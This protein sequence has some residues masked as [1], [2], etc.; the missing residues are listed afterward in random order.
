MCM[1]L[2]HVISKTKVPVFSILS[3]GIS[4]SKV[5]TSKLGNLLGQ[6]PRL[7]RGDVGWRHRGNAFGHHHH[8]LLFG[9]PRF[10]SGSCHCILN[11]LKG[12]AKFSDLFSA[13]KQYV[14]Y[15]GQFL[16]LGLFYALISLAFQSVSIAGGIMNN[17]VLS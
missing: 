7:D 8:R 11:A 14:K 13:L 9:H 4:I 1:Q 5:A 10:R 15:L 16:M 6:L 2:R 3:L 17:S 12:E